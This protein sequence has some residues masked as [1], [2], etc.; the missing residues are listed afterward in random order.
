MSESDQ[1]QVV[2]IQVR[3]MGDGT[4]YVNPACIA[5]ISEHAFDGCELH[6]TVGRSLIVCES[7]ESFIDRLRSEVGLWLVEPE[8]D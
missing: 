4:A 3:T 6:L 8:A 2:L 1:K 5:A 7:P